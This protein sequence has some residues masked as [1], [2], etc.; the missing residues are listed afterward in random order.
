MKLAYLLLC[1]NTPDHTG[2]LV[3]AL[4]AEGNDIYVHL[5]AKSDLPINLPAGTAVSYVDDNVPVYW[6]EF[7]QVQAI[8]LLMKLALRSTTEYDYLVLLSGSDYPVRSQAYIKSFFQKNYGCE[9]INTVKMPNEQLGKPL[10]RLTEFR[11][12]S[13]RR[14]LKP[15][16]ELLVRLSRLAGGGYPRRDYRRAL[17]GLTPYAG[18]TWWALTAGAC[19]HILTFCDAHARFVDYFKCTLCPD[20]MFFQTII[21]NSGFAEK[22][23]HNLTYVDWD[24][25][26]PPFP[27]WI[28]PWHLEHFRANRPLHEEDAYGEGELLFVRKFRDDSVSLTAQID[29]WLLNDG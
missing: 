24:R 4:T 15:A 14:M 23:R 21:G 3:E 10:T 22:I 7:S 1:H 13:D 26:G 29:E 5:D 12:G 19:R 9:F 2:R 27:A 25:F 16:S 28:N 18:S 17:S 8:L 20:E 6:G 11:P